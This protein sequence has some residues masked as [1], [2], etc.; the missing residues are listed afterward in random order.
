MANRW[1]DDETPGPTWPGAVIVLA[2][3]ALICCA[4]LVGWWG[5]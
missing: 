5:R 1:E 4:I 3:V 2:A